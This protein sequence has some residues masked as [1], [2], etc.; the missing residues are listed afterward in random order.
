MKKSL[1]MSL[2]TV[3]LTLG[4]Y[5]VRLAQSKTTDFSGRWT[6][7]KDKTSDLP[8]TLES[9]MLTVTQ[10]T[11]RL[12][13]ESELKGELGMR[14]GPRGQGGGRRGDGA[15]FPG[16]GP[17]GGPPGGGP[18][19][20]PP[21]GG[22]GGGP[23]GPGAPGGG[24]S[25]PKDVIM[26]MALRLAIPSATY[27]VD[28]KETMQQIEAREASDDQPPQPSGILTLKASWK[29]NGKALELKSVRK[30]KTPEGD[31]SMINKE[32][33]EMSEDGQTLT[34]KRTIDMPMG[35]EEVKLIFTRQ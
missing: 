5:G 11:R 33:W 9:Y 19:G 20:G 23:P 35:A 6:L 15:G 26:G 2:F 31:L 10:D 8:P 18:G 3:A 14:V 30:F 22:P 21:G 24:F 34:V 28:G 12:T 32:F 13:V 17:G 29:K 16:G 25:L 7:D 4:L 1:A 27:M